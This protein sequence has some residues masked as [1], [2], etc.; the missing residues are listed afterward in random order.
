MP[1]RMPIESGVPDPFQYMHPV[2]TKNYGA[3]KYP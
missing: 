1:P 3:W 2:M